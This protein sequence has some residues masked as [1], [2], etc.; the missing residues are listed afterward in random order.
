AADRV[1]VG[2]A[3]ADLIHVEPANYL[4]VV[5]YV[6]TLHVRSSLLQIPLQALGTA[7]RAGQIG[8]GD[9]AAQ[10]GHGRVHVLG[11]LA[12]GDRP[13]FAH[14]LVPGGAARLLLTG[15]ELVPHTNLLKFL[16]SPSYRRDCDIGNLGAS[17]VRMICVRP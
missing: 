8:R 11:E 3:A 15:G 12:D 2:P 16:I 1:P 4:A 13:A 14:Q 5:D 10:V 9:R 7:H 17:Y 6:H